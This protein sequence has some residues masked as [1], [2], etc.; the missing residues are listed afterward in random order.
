MGGKFL[1]WSKKA[2][3]A[4]GANSAGASAEVMAGDLFGMGDPI[5]GRQFTVG[6]WTKAVQGPK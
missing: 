2:T 3:G 6:P 5:F 4:E 1:V